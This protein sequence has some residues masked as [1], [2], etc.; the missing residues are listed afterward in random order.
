MSEPRVYQDKDEGRWLDPLGDGNL[1]PLNEQLC[2]LLS[3]KYPV[4]T[5][6]DVEEE[7]G[8][9]T[10]LT[11]P[12]GGGEP[13]NCEACWHLWF[14]HGERGCGAQVYPAHSLTGEPCPCEHQG[15]HVAEYQRLEAGTLY[16]VVIPN[17]PL[18]LV[19]IRWEGDGR[20][21]A[22]TLEGKRLPEVPP[23]ARAAVHAYVAD[24]RP[25]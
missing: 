16:R 23:A 2:R 25:S 18:R 5:R 4:C 20:L 17:G 24:R 21:T 12:A 13:L 15:A 1:V 6:R 9:L 19:Y 8:A 22:E 14:L 3:A 7:F 10:E 11:A